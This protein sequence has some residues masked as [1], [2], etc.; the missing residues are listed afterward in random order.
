MSF[1][2]RYY[3]LGALAYRTIFRYRN[4]LHGFGYRT[5]RPTITIFTSFISV[6]DAREVGVVKVGKKHPAR[7]LQ[8]DFA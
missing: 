2:L 7:L 6:V 8:A 5:C 1:S 4:S 3:G